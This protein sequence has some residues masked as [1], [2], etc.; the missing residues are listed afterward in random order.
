MHPESVTIESIT[1]V[2]RHPDGA[3]A[4]VL[5]GDIR[6]SSIAPVYAAAGRRQ[7]AYSHT[8]VQ[9]AIGEMVVS[10]NKRMIAA[11][12]RRANINPDK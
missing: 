9:L 6:A 10:T 3:R 8:N 2:V 12:L 7:E 4:V 11:A 5:S 1:F